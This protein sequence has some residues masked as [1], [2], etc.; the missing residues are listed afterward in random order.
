MKTE[1]EKK[2]AKNL[3]WA[4]VIMLCLVLAVLVLQVLITKQ[5]EAYE[6]ALTDFQYHT[7]VKLEDL[8]YVAEEILDDKGY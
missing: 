2:N 4:D 3:N 7:S 6:I 8:N 5:E 1:K